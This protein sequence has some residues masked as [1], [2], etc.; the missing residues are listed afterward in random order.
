MEMGGIALVNYR[1]VPR[2]WHTRLLLHPI[3]TSRW[4]IATPDLD[5]YDEDLSDQNPDFVGFHY[6]GPGGQIP[7]HISA[8][9]VYGFA[10]MSATQLGQLMAQGRTYA[11]ANGAQAQADPGP[12]AAP[13]AAAPVAGVGGGGQGVAVGLADR[14]IAMEKGGQY[15]RGDL[16]CIDPAPLPQ[17]CSVLDSL[18]I[19]AVDGGHICLRKMT[20]AEVSAFVLDDLRVLPVH[21]DSEGIRRRAFNMC[22][23][24]MSGQSPQGGVCSFLGLPH[25]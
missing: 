8:R 5:I 14:W 13:V 19:L 21:F 20:Q 24:K 17:G 12:Q 18:A 22:V 15:A 9:T 23:E 6:S 7:P 16:V 2:C 10:P 25:V 4:V 1:E 3:A 11:A